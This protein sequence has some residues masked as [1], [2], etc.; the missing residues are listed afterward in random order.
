MVLKK[1]VCL[2][3]VA[4][5]AALLFCRLLDTT[6]A[7]VMNL[8]IDLMDVIQEAAASWRHKWKRDELS[9]PDVI[10]TR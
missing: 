10:L 7:F 6:D 5:A 4:S 8:E 2:F 1:H 9:W 3:I